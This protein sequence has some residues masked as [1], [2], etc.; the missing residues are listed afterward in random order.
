MK[1]YLRKYRDPDGDWRTG[2]TFWVRFVVGGTRFNVTTGAR[3]KRAAELIA[4]DLLRR[5]ELRRAGIVDPTA[6]QFERPIKEHLDDFERTMR[7]RGV[8]ERYV[9]DRRGCLEDLVASTGARTLRD[10]DLPKASAWLTGFKDR[11]LGARSVNRRYQA[12][13]Q[14]GLWLVKT[15]RVQFDPFDGLK[16]LNEAEDR[17]HVRRA[18]TPEEA[19]RLVHA[20][21]TRLLTWTYKGR[22]VGPTCDAERARL[23]RLGET[24]AIVYLLA[25]GTGL[26]KGELRRLRW[27]D[28]DLDRG[29]V[30]VTAASAKSRK[31]QS[32]PIGE[33][34]VAALKAA[35]PA[36]A[37]PTD[38]VVPP[39]AF[40][41]TLTFHRDLEA[42]GIER[43]ADGCVIDF[44][45]LRTT[46]ISWLAAAGTH[47]RVA[48]ILAR[49]ASVE[50]T[51]ERY[52]D[53]R[54]LDLRGAIA[55]L[56]LPG[57]RNGKTSRTPAPT[58]TWDRRGDRAT[59]S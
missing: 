52:T 9:E 36:G 13:K 23:A 57:G 28:L 27:C 50:T 1:V 31:D 2:K 22:P 37:L 5:E 45:A 10:L 26:R 51:M 19:E 44:H 56:P 46:F 43:E 25:M 24:R 12:A 34:L 15:R 58:R 38:A 41:N 47:P 30:A 59:V 11:G 16:P 48:Q 20:A 6:A 7:A 18:L 49:H 33:T 21:R 39:G 55:G 8:V 17:R 42:A 14:F 4:A 35:R 3:D 29:S 54:L 40:P 53:T 32:V